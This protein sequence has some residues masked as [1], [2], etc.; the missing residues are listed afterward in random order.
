MST[1]T[2]TGRDSVAVIG[3]LVVT[4]LYMPA[5]AL[6]AWGGGNHEFQFYIVT[7]ALF[8]IAV[9]QIHRYVRLSPGVL[10][11]LS[12]WGAAHLAGGMVTIPPEWP[13]EGAPVLYNW[14]LIGHGLKFDQMVHA[15]GFGMVT[16]TCW[17]GLRW[18]IAHRWAVAPARV[19]PTAGLLVLCVAAGMGFGALNE[20]VEFIATLC[21]RDTNVGGYINTGWDLVSNLAGSTLTALLIAAA[22]RPSKNT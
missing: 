18:A 6:K 13:A 5:G 12:A 21:V 17:Q 7:M 4:A 15:Y 3:V 19:R 20:V 1:R 10:W 11:G 8:I 22:H 9:T 16:W 2:A 14:W